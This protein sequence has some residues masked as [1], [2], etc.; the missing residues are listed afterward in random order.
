MSKELAVAEPKSEVAVIFEKINTGMQAFEARKEELMLLAKEAEDIK[1]TTYE[2]KAN[3]KRATELRKKIK[4]ARVKV[5][6]EGK[7]MRDPLNGVNKEISA[8]QNELVAIVSPSE[9][10]LQEIE[11]WYDAEKERLEIEEKMA[12]EE[13][14]QNRVD[15]LRAY[16]C[17]IDL[18]YLKAIDDEQFET[19]VARAKVEFD[20]DE[21]DKA[22]R[23]RIADE[24]RKELEE[25]RKQKADADKIIQDRENEKAKNWEQER[26]RRQ[27]QMYD[28]GLVYD[29][30]DNHYKG[31]DCFVASL[32][33]T[34]M[35][36]DRWDTEMDKMR[37]HILEYKERKAV[38]DKERAEK[39]A[40]EEKL[41]RGRLYELEDV[42]WNGQE[43][44]AR[45]DESIV[46]ATHEQ[47]I[48]LGDEDFL[49][50]KTNHNSK[51]AKAKEDK[52]IAEEQRL[53]KIRKDAADK[54]IAD[55]QTQKEEAERQEAE[56]LAQSSDKE[57]FDVILSHYNSTPYPEM[58]SAKHKKLLAEVKDLNAK[59]I[60]HIKAKA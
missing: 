14:I 59:V 48:T 11:D 44:T 1:V 5:E 2:D 38:A 20:K 47:L 13:R 42:R 55:A 3:L 4:A 27:Q 54:A 17:E 31:F 45:Y 51:N 22:E 52:R 56:R 28:F 10:S 9:R 57:K 7:A 19:L 33:I 21:A 25:L 29:F 30:N 26:K 53:E 15:K 50:V 49:Y 41:W 8:K 60:A 43:A 40:A 39:E 34:T 36:Q 18:V 24:E 35:E 16:N 46:V 23:Q 32:D 37:L 58:K 6:N 12:E